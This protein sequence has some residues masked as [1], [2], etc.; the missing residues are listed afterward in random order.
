MEPIAVLGVGCRFPGGIHNPDSFWNAILEKFDAISDI[1][2][3]RWSRN[4]FCSANDGAPGKMYIE[5]GGFLSQPLDLFDAA[6]FGISPREAEFLD[7]QQRLLLE[8]AWEALE[9]AGLDPRALAGTDVGVY[10]GGFTLDHML[11]QMGASN[12]THIGQH[13]AAGST[14]TMLSNRVSHAF[15]FRG[16]SI[17]MDTACSSSMV[18]LHQACQAIWHDECSMAMVG[19]V[20]VMLRPE[21]PIAMCKGGFLAKDSH[22]K[23]F[24]ARGDGYA[25][26]EGAGMVV[27]KPAS[28]AVRDGDPILALIHATGV[29]QDGRTNGITVPSGPA[30]EALMRRVLK[31]AGIDPAEV[32]YVEAHGTGTAVSDPTEA[33]AI[34]AVYGK[35]RPPGADPCVIGSVKSNIGHLE[36]AAGVA[37]LIKAVLCLRNRLIPPLA[38][39]ETPNPDI[40]FDELGLRLADRT[41][42]LGKSDQ[43]VYVGINS[44]G[45]GG[46]NAHALLSS[47]PPIDELA[48]SAPTT[49]DYIVPLSAQSEP[50]L[51]ELATS[52]RERLADEGADLSDFAYSA[53]VRR[54]HLSERLAV[55][56]RDR[57]SLLAA[58]DGFLTAGRGDAIDTGK[59]PYAGTDRPVFVFTGMGPQWWGM[60][61]ELW[62]TEPVYQQAAREIDAIFRNIAGF[63]VLEEMLKDEASSRITETQIAQPANFL[64]QVGL[65]R[66][67]ASYGIEPGAVV[68]HS[69]GEVSA[70]HVAGV[71]SLEDAIRVS[72]HRSRIQK[73]AAGTG[74]MLAVGLPEETVLPLLE[75]MEDAVSI[76][77]VNSPSGVTLAGRTEQ[78]QELAAL[79]TDQ[80]VFNRLLQVEVPYHS[81]MMVPLKE[82]LLDCLAVIRPGQAQIPLYSTVTGQ[83]VEGIA[84]DAP[85]WY[86]NVR[87]PAHFAKAIRSLLDDDCRIF[88]EI[89]PHP[90]LSASLKECF[91]HARQDAR[92]VETLRRNQPEKARVISSVAGLYVAGGRVDWSRCYP[93]SNLVRLPNYPWQ[94][95][96][97]WTESDLA[98]GDRLRDPEHPLLGLQTSSPV[99]SWEAE[100]NRNYLPYIDDHKIDGLVLFPGAGYVEAFLQVHREAIGGSQATLRDVTF[101]KALILDDAQSSILSNLYNPETRSATISSRKLIDPA[102][103][104][105]H[106]RAVLYTHDGRDAGRNDLDALRAGLGQPVDVDALYARLHDRGCNTDGSSV[107]SVR[108]TVAETRCLRRLR[109]IRRWPKTWGRTVRIRLFSTVASSRLSRLSTMPGRT[110]AMCPLPS[111]SSIS[112]IRWIRWSGAAAG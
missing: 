25:R 103:W 29:N 109:P 56:G 69:V 75:G 108:S 88:L 8:V 83:R 97:L 46:T 3:D 107:R 2:T 41:M 94:R 93:R 13:T 99:P 31:A 47:A 106:A 77:A 45:Y 65:T 24:D 74:L 89:G 102:G 80:G 64:I 33:A 27:L 21:Y 85:Y 14:M 35:G 1:P 28:S 60:G 16:P 53:A 68:G 87:Q 101:S 96:H 81:P 90:V 98:R 39:L 38:T 37:G 18:A 111:G 110:P 12:R 61:Q 73:K 6:F 26:G 11:N 49:G 57:A 76:A 112:T 84:Y 67:L 22:C 59:A 32:H 20:N 30:Q 72:H 78:I 104:S 23:S 105:T 19:G 91:A 92:S 71:L 58:L 9:N 63:S 7:P 70:A 54:G 42:P 95:E 100:L 44:F 10:V 50:A 36:A 43:T 52:F 5:K 48:P 66:L 55:V 79:F 15:D 82:E 17:S 40:P 86:R 34:G 62:R 51:K 4:K